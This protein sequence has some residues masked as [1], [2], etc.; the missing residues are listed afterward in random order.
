MFCLLVFWFQLRH[1]SH[2]ACVS[3]DKC[4]RAG[5]RQGCQ[6]YTR[7]PNSVLA[8]RHP[9]Q[10][11]TPPPCWQQGFFFLMHILVLIDHQPYGTIVLWVS[12][13][14]TAHSW[15]YNNYTR[16]WHCT[17]WPRHIWEQDAESG[18]CKLLQAEMEGLVG[19][20]S[21]RLEVSMLRPNWWGA[22]G[23]LEERAE[24][25]EVS[26]VQVFFWASIRSL[27]K[28]IILNRFLLMRKKQ[29]HLKWH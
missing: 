27:F 5:A 14:L 28:W 24:W 26:R 2:H 9:N 11:P 19:N 16:L 21:F 6:Q 4:H 13:L 15:S 3:Q 22:R 25:R 29:L 1:F 20:T 10:R 12:L 7:N 17:N 18:H 8:S 23:W